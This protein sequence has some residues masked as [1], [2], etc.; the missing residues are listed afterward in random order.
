LIYKLSPDEVSVVAF[1]H[2]A[3]DLRRIWEGRDEAQDS[4][5]E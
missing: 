2:G 4:D 3:R 5:D 1:V